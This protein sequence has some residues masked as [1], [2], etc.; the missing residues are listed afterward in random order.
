VVDDDALLRGVIAKVLKKADYLVLEAPDGPSALEITVQEHPDIILLD[1][2]MAGMS[3]YEVVQQIR[4]IPLMSSIPI[5]LLTALNETGDKI[6]GI[7][8]GADDYITKPFNAQELLARLEMHLRRSWRDVQ[9]NPLTSLP[10][11][12]AI[13]LALRQ[14]IAKGG[15]LVVCYIDV[16]DFKPFNDKYGFLIGDDVLL[17]L[18]QCVLDAVT[19]W[20]DVHEDFVGHEG[21]DDFVVLTIP[22]RAEKIAQ[23]IIACFDEQ[24]PAFYNDEDRARGYM[25]GKDRRGNVV[26]IPIVS[27]SIAIVT[28]L[29]R[30]LIHPRQVAQIAAEVKQRIK[31]LSG[32]NYG[33]DLRQENG[34]G[35]LLLPDS[36]SAKANLPTSEANR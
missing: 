35:D 7:T 11:N 29:Y 30:A 6:R 33:F 17:A 10:G 2:M 18:S 16:D 21:G 20:G 5:I 3:G 31:A 36:D 25:I 15:P 1:V 9:S 27:V 4:S 13:E 26:A 19:R 23:D 24:V 22:E 12:R 14:R 34:K 32:S 8:L 28:N